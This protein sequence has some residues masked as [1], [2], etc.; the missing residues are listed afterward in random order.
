MDDDGNFFDAQ[1]P[2]GPSIRAELDYIK[3]VQHQLDTKD[4]KNIKMGYYEVDYW[5]RKDIVYPILPRKNYNHDKTFVRADGLI[6]DLK[7]SSG[8]YTTVDLIEAHKKGYRIK[9]KH[10][11]YWE[12]TVALFKEY[13]EIGTKIKMEGDREKNQA[14]RTLGKL[15][16]NA[17]Y[18]KTLQRVIEELMRICTMVDEVT[19]FMVEGILKNLIFCNDKSQ[20]ILLK[21]EF[22]FPKERLDKPNHLG[23]FILAYSRKR[24]NFYYNLLNPFDDGTQIDKAMMYNFLYRDTD[25]YYFVVREDTWQRLKPFIDFDKKITGYLAPDFD[26]NP[27]LIELVIPA[28][29][30]MFIRAL[31]ED[32]TEKEIYKTKGCE[33]GAVGYQDFMDVLQEKDPKPVTLSRI[34][35]TMNSNKGNHPFTMQNIAVNKIFLRRPW[36]GRI[37]IGNSSVPYYFQGYEAISQEREED[38]LLLEKIRHTQRD[39]EEEGL[40]FIDSTF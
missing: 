14:K 36:D 11:I 9:L 8:V 12:K 1:Y 30:T 19:R 3:Q 31:Y 13:C 27:K 18:G 37:F 39:E 28:P 5:P 17:L 10:G 4:Y 16:I 23:G 38:Y 33:K 20:T 40:E 29:K 32:G 35:K 22:R 15:L 24:M 34:Q 7:D 26:G 25:C 6:W 2:V 21:G